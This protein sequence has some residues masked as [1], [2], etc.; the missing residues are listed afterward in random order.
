MNPASLLGNTEDLSYNPEYT[1]NEKQRFR[2][3]PKAHNAYR[4]KLIHNINDGFK[5]VS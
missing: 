2:N 3:E 1:A 5:M 4:K